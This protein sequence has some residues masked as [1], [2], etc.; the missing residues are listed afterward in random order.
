MRKLREMLLGMSFALFIMVTASVPFSGQESADQ[1]RLRDLE[2]DQ[3]PLEMKI[4]DHEGRL[5]RLEDAVAVFKSSSE[6][7]TWWMRGIGAALALAV[8][9]RV[10][11][12]AGVI[13]K[14]GSDG[15]GPVG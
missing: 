4:Q 13:G 10:L 11:R 6:E 5:I 14:G 3:V 1:V 7:G 2:R 12:T 8:L 15:L 9:E